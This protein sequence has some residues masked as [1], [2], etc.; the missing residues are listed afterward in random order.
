MMIALNKETKQIV[1][2]IVKTLGIYIILS[3]FF[4]GYIGLIDPRGSLYSSFLAKYSLVDFI[5]TA[6]I[7]PTKAVLGWLGFHVISYNNNLSIAN[8]KGILIFHAC[9]GIE[10]MIGYTALMLGYPGKSKFLF[11]VIGI[12]FVHLLNVIR[13]SLIV[14]AIKKD[15]SIADLSHD[16]FNYVAYCLIICL[17]YF[18]VK[19]Y[20]KGLS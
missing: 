18:W 3:V 14:I 1:G 7:I 2:I 19:F 17:F 8:E 15:P 9:L 13:M 4:Y 12:F 10:V 6:L 16:I 5:L 20:G 11:F